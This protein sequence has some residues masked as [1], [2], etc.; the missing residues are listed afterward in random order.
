MNGQTR[1]RCPK[2]GAPRTD[3]VDSRENLEQTRVRRRRECPRCGHRFT[4]YEDYAPD[5]FEGT[6]N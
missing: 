3:V 6:E 2:C 1:I 4:T 5:T